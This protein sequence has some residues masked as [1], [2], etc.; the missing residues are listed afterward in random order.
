MSLQD[1]MKT[2]LISAFFLILP[3]AVFAQVDDV[4]DELGTIDDVEAETWE[5]NYDV[6]TDLHEH[7]INLNTATREE[8]EQLPFLENLKQQV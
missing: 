6:L 4:A 3:T 7:P 1:V 2:R 8:L 5:Q